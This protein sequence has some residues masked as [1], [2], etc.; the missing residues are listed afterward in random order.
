L[1]AKLTDIGL[2]TFYFLIIGFVASQILDSVFILDKTPIK[3]KSSIRLFIEIFLQIFTI[4]IVYYF[5]RN[6][7]ER[8]PFPVEG[9]GGF[10]HKRLKE[11][12]GTTILGIAM[13]SF[14]K[15]LTEKMNEFINRLKK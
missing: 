15:K 5:L 10:Q 8:I 14:S 1:F 12:S 2:V 4:G 3:E 7:V 6:I 11:L 9:I 13:I